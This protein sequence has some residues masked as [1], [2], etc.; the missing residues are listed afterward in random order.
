MIWNYLTILC[1]ITA[2]FTAVYNKSSGL[3]DNLFV[4]PIAYFISLCFAR[5]TFRKQSGLSLIIIEVIMFCRFIMIP[6]LYALTDN[7]SGVRI[8]SQLSEAVWYMA[9][10]EIAVGILIQSSKYTATSLSS[11]NFHLSGA[12]PILSFSHDT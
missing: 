8:S 12:T 9:Y 6:I 1:I 11:D 3:V 10:E 4:L 5:K 7:Y 2:F